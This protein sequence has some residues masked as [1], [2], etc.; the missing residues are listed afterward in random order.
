[1]SLE[2]I[3]AGFGRTGT[4]SLKLALEQLG[5][6]PC[7]HMN[8]VFQHPGH[9]QLWRDAFVNQSA[10]W[11]ALFEGYRAAVDWPP[12][13]FW[14]QLTDHAPEA[15]VILTVRDRDAWYNSISSTIFPA[16]R[17]PLP[18]EDDPHF[19]SLVMPRELIL[20]G[21]FDGIEDKDHVLAIYDTHNAAVQAEIA[22][23]RLLVYDVANGWEPLCRFLGVSVPDAPFPRSNTQQEFL[24]RLKKPGV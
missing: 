3:G 16:Q 20:R 1:M 5:R 2:I 11:D 17:R 6:G 21:T 8:D 4:L 19:A 24:N 15:Q 22:P 14:R 12:A 13:H 10:D 18:A 23:D 7:Y 9:A